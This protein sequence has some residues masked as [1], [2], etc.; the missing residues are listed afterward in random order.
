M[1]NES[2][3]PRTAQLLPNTIPR[4]RGG[5]LTSLP[6]PAGGGGERLSA[7]EHRAPRRA[8]LLLQDREKEADGLREIGGSERR[9]VDRE[10]VGGEG[11]GRT[12]IVLQTAGLLELPARTGASRCDGG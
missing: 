1:N 11:I 9:G 2:P 6:G 4:R 8:L 5:Y 3:D 12:A 10:A 7:A